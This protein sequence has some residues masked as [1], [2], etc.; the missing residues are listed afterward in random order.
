MRKTKASPPAKSKNSIATKATKARTQTSPIFPLSQIPEGFFSHY[1]RTPGAVVYPEQALSLSP[2]F[3][4]LRLYQNT[5]GNLPLVTYRRDEKGR[6]R[7]RTHPAYKLL[8]ERP[9]PAQS[10]AAFF[11]FAVKELFLHGN[12]FAT[13]SWAGNG[14]PL[15]LYPI[16]S[17]AVTNIAVLSDWR[18][19][20][21]VQTQHGP[22]TIEDDDMIHVM[23]PYSHCG[24][25][26]GNSFIEFAAESLGLHRQVLEAATSFY[27]NAARP[28]VYVSF[29][30]V[31]DKA[32]MEI[33][34]KAFKEEYTGSKNTGKTACLTNGGKIE[35]FPG[36][37]ADDA[38]I[39]TALN[40]SVADIARWFGLSPLLLGDLLRGTYNNVAADNLAFY[41]K[42]LAPLLNRFELEINHRLFGADEDFY[43]EFLT[44]KLLQG[45]PKQQAEIY[46]SGIQA[47]YLLRSEVREW[48]NLSA[49]EG[50]DTPL[51][52]LN[53]GPEMGTKALPPVTA[54]PQEESDDGPD[55]SDTPAA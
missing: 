6:S 21:T 37:T 1:R 26:R 35:K 14:K 53:M 28:N 52:P 46:Q 44:Q 13:I 42:S 11:E 4:G 12:F 33:N 51:F 32:A 22:D 3:A 50:L 31:P 8:S 5:L 36:D 15:A 41:Q 17:V 43:A 9:N 24:V 10:R 45:D 48:L 2:F 20:Y 30:G 29:P 18:K 39:L 40:A 49:V 54:P 25:V 55:I 23:G 34:K 19:R 38:Q 16:P 47:G 27:S 7:A